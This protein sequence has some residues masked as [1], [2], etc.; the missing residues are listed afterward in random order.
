MLMKAVMVADNIPVVLPAYRII[1]C[2]WSYSEVLHCMHCIMMITIPIL[3]DCVFMMTH[4][5]NL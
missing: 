5:P 2:S 4:M 1:G 3:M